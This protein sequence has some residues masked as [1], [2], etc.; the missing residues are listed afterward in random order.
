MFIGVMR[1]GGGVGI[2]AM[3][4]CMDTTVPFLRTNVGPWAPLIVV[5]TGLS[6]A[7]GDTGFVVTAAGIAAIGVLAD[8]F[9]N[10]AG[11]A[12]AAIND[13]ANES[14]WRKRSAF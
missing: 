9:N 10:V 14:P 13:A 7:S 11:D 6:L 4:S 2:N 5:M 8:T 3:I 1:F 12:I